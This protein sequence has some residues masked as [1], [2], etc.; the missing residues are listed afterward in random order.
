MDLLGG[1]EQAD[2]GRSILELFS[3]IQTDIRDILD[4]V[5][6]NNLKVGLQLM[7]ETV[8]FYGLFGAATQI[9][10]RKRQLQILT[11]M[12]D[13]IKKFN[14]EI[15]S[16]LE[17]KLS[18]LKSSSKHGTF[19]WI[20]SI[21]CKALREGSWL[22][23]DNVNLCSASVLDRLNALFEHGGKLTVSERGVLDGEIPEVKPHPDFRVF[24]LYDPS[25]GDIS[26]A[27]RNRGV[28]I[29][30]P[31]CQEVNISSIDRMGFVSANLS[32][33]ISSDS[34]VSQALVLSHSSGFKEYTDKISILGL[35]ALSGC[36]LE[37]SQNILVPL[38]HRLCWLLSSANLLSAYSELGRIS[39]QLL[40]VLEVQDNPE[41]ARISFNYFMNFMSKA[42]SNIRLLVIS[43]IFQSPQLTDICR[44]FS[45]NKLFQSLYEIEFT[46]ERT[47]WE[48]R[49]LPSGRSQQDDLPNRLSLI[50]VTYSKFKELQDR[51][52][53]NPKCLLSKCGNS[54][55][56]SSKVLEQFPSMVMSLLQAIETE[57]NK[58]EPMSNESWTEFDSFLFWLYELGDLGLQVP[59]RNQEED[60]ERLLYVYWFW[61]I[62]RLS[63][64][65]KSLN[66]SELKSVFIKFNKVIESLNY[67]SN[68]FSRFRAITELCPVP[69]QTLESLEILHNLS[70][71]E[72]FIEN[73]DVKSRINFIAI[74]L[75]KIEEVLVKY[76]N[77]EIEMNQVSADILEIV[78][79]FSP[80]ESCSSA[81][82]YELQ[83]AAV[84]S[85]LNQL[86]Q[87]Q[88]PNNV[89]LPIN[90]RLL[91]YRGE[92]DMETR[93]RTQLYYCNNTSRSI[94]ALEHNPVNH[95]LGIAEHPVNCFDASSLVNHLLVGSG[96]GVPLVTFQE[97]REQILNLV[98]VLK[99]FK[100]PDVLSKLR[101]Q[102]DTEMKI[103]LNG[104]HKAY[105]C[106]DDNVCIDSVL[107][108]GTM[109]VNVLRVLKA[110]SIRSR[111]ET[112]FSAQL[113][114]VLLNLLKLHIFG[115]LGAI[116]PAEKQAL[117]YKQT[118]KELESVRN[119]ILV[120]DQFYDAV[121]TLHPHRSI[122][123]ERES[124]LEVSSSS[125]ICRTAERGTQSFSL[126]SNTVKHYKDSIGSVST[127]LKLVQDLENLHQDGTIGSILQETEVWMKS[128]VKFSSDLLEHSS[129]PD[130]VLP[131][132]ESVTTAVGAVDAAVEQIRQKTLRDKCS[133]LEKIVLLVSDPV[134]S[135]GE[136]LNSVFQFYLDPSVSGLLSNNQDLKILKSCLVFL[137]QSSTTTPNLK[138]SPEHL[139]ELV[140]RILYSWRSEQELKKKKELEDEAVFKTR[141]VC[142]EEDE[143]KLAE[144]EFKK[145]FPSFKE[146]FADISNTDN[147]NED[148]AENS[149]AEKPSFSPV[150]LE[151]IK[152]IASF[153]LKFGTTD[154]SSGLNEISRTEFRDRW[155]TINSLISVQ[156]GVNSLP[157]ETSLI[158]SL[159]TLANSFISGVD[160]P[161]FYNFY[162]D[163]NE[164]ETKLMKP[165][166]LAM[167]SSVGNLLEEFPENPL[168][169][170][171]LVIRDR[172]LTFPLESPLSKNLTGLE[173]LLGSCQ[174][175]EKNAHRGVSIQ[176]LM[177]SISVLILRWRKLELSNWKPI[178][179]QSLETLRNASSEFWLHVMGVVLEAKNKTE[180]VR[181]LIQFIEAS[182]LA[183]F[184]TRLEILQSA[185]KTMLQVGSNK[186]WLISALQN[187]QEYYA[188]FQES[189]DSRLDA[190]FK[191]SEKKVGE[192][193]KMARWKDT[194]FWSVKNM[195][196]KTRKVLHKALREYKKAVSEPCKNYFIDEGS[197]TV[198][199]GSSPVGLDQVLE[200]STVPSTPLVYQ[201]I[202]NLKNIE[203][204]SYEK[205]S[206]QAYNIQRKILHEIRNRN[207]VEPI[208][209]LVPNIVTEMEKL[210]KLDVTRSKTKEE[211]KKQA[212]FIQQRKRRA[213][214]DLFKTLQGL[215]L[216]YRH[217]LMN[218]GD[219]NTNDELFVKLNYELQLWKDCEKYFFR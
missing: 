66:L 182:S 20:D 199:D 72:A 184:K 132:I 201:N 191:G 11:E 116:D 45:E 2:I 79:S 125:M 77:L 43:L 153:I 110:L 65:I 39:Y 95:S 88:D 91:M 179:A 90:L 188:R 76:K 92:E 157:L 193:V 12:I 42:D 101:E 149:V 48:S 67:D 145:L 208:S 155:R 106:I 156:P 62:K 97:K 209:E 212:G 33:A 87:V 74:C 14:I 121:G 25:R 75:P 194:N 38:Q 59:Q 215:G 192:F 112:I 108:I 119:Q 200:I 135:P 174:E 147:L 5:L 214:N 139:H 172:I 216:S 60:L 55:S 13:M 162:T 152:D 134:I 109:D 51:V 185:Q 102:F 61:M 10:K 164:E 180:T 205:L 207:L 130:L 98:K 54:F 84:S 176:N 40:P 52:N 217:G 68:S 166:L 211:Q 24:L 3:Q 50:L 197:E 150:R 69:P 213:L 141:T 53:L 124:N 114:I 171:I 56:L 137:K 29:Y 111:S 89:F 177:D 178:L 73:R 94:L 168:L 19:E 35:Q 129:F 104:L 158:P 6:E 126:I 203:I 113:D 82:F 100:S 7:E 160:K 204:G 16:E 170:Q 120:I 146:V 206:K 210:Q 136:N 23:I 173:L 63:P 103:I 41:L 44:K 131:I 26:R 18:L 127:L 27:M 118:L 140:S 30:V 78:S 151:I 37:D 1:F 123:K 181:A 9:K 198:V 80:S 187:I 31:S 189:I 8:R 148:I 117:K 163:P 154:I 32:S 169:L 58:H 49:M 21:L 96:T 71:T 34:A 70:E 142:S 28:E 190:L 167:G 138:V 93:A 218:C 183:D 99:N 196:E 46:D 105:D 159:I 81:R 4:Q 107:G 85:R 128:S 161:K 202:V 175:W 195:V 115:S 36:A 47:V 122:L 57:L 83:L 15:Y 143:E 64:L 144:D 22:L 165:L 219:L 86:R 186:K 133:D 17:E